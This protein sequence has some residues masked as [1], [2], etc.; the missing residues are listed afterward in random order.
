M[1]NWSAREEGD[2]DEA[3]FA[4]FDYLDARDRLSEA[5]R[6]HDEC[7]DAYLTNLHEAEIRRSA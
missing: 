2:R 6:I 5:K 4:W 3:T 7:D 1:S